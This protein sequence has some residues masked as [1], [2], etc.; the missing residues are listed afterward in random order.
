VRIK[1]VN[2]SFI[3]L[4]AFL[5]LGNQSAYAQS[6]EE[7]RAMWTFNIAAGVTWEDEQN[8]DEF[9][10]GVYSDRQTYQAMRDIA[11]SRKVHGKPVKVI[12][13]KSHTNIEYVHILFIT[14]NESGYADVIYNK[15]KGKNVLLITDR[16]KDERLSVIN[17]LPIG[18][19]AKAF[20]IYKPLADKQGLKFSKLLLKLGGS[21]EVIRDMF[22][23][24]E[25]ELREEQEKLEKQRQRIAEQE[26]RLKKQLAQI[27][28]QNKEIE[29]K[30]EQIEL[31]EE[32]LAEQSSRLDSTVAEVRKQ[33]ESLIKNLR[34]L[35]VQEGKIQ[36]QQKAMREQAERMEK[37]DKEL[38][39][40]EA[41]IQERDQELGVSQQVIESQEEIILL[42]IIGSVIIVFLTFL[43][44]RGYYKKQ[45]INKKLNEQNVAI[46][47]QKEEILSQSKQLEMINSELEKLSIV[48]SKTDNAVTILN[49]E[50]DFE[51]VNAGFTRMYGY[52]LQLLK[53]EQDKN[54][55]K[56]SVNDEIEEIFERARTKKETVIY[57][58]E[59]QTRDGNRLWVQT[60]LNPI[61]N[62]N[63]KV[64]KFITIDTDISKLKEAEMEI[65]QKSEELE[66]QKDALEQQ[67]ERIDFQ[68]NQI[69]SSIQY[70][71]NIQ[72][73]ILPSADQLQE[74]FNAF[75]LFRPKDIVSGDF[76]W[77]AKLPAVKGFSEKIFVAAVDCTGHGVPG[78]FMSLVASRMLNEI[79]LERKIINPAE[80]LETLDERVNKALRQDETDNHDGMDLVL[81]RL[82]K[83]DKNGDYNVKF[84]GAKRP[85]YIKKTEENG[86][87]ILDGT[88]RSIGGISLRKKHQKPFETKEI[89]VSKGDYMWLSTDGYIDQNDET[90][91]RFGSP[92][93]ANVL[94]TIK[95]KPLNDQYKYLQKTL[96]AYKGDA[97]QRDDITVLGIE[98]RE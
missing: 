82:E 12:Q 37:A 60:T 52:T 95:E 34:I 17:F 83:F 57:E 31:K 55:I 13:Y 24:T 54:I 73:A 58:N 91:K 89:T 15:F 6:D 10:I 87:N 96:D 23:Q 70:A 11:K 88:R 81:C 86:I 94:N 76:Y 33:R 22:S 39:E 48:A 80:I 44:L 42:F 92:R 93:F 35:A 9:L 30:E 97:P 4:I 36:E 14:R 51:W 77:Y 98:I 20:N 71:K 40:K 62:D 38:Q 43:T 61:L 64:V 72:T 75:V 7:K 2:I 50:G 74:L 79:V 84:A 67:N 8:I 16:I 47:K 27:E 90:R 5:T 26:A 85:L 56:A 18:E 69:K 46:N 63:G 78:A 25:R 41:K 21:E 28:K 1:I 66:M 65:R 3:F 32:E 45:K 19:Q 53:H 29:A 49:A 59:N 68:N